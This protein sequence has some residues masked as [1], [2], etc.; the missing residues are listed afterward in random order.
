MTIQ[1]YQDVF[2]A[3]TLETVYAGEYLESNGLRFGVD[4]GTSDAIRKATDLIL[5]RIYE[6]E[7][8]DHTV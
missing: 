3:L 7:K 2:Q 1:G 5:E 6:D 8:Y 4:F